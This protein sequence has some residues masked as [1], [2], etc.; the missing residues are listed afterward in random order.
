[1]SNA[2]YS[3]AWAA[4]QVSVGVCAWL[5]MAS[6][7]KRSSRR[8]HVKGSQRVACAVLS[9]KALAAALGALGVTAG[10]LHPTRFMGQATDM[11]GMSVNQ[12]QSTRS[13]RGVRTTTGLPST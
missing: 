10:W 4:G 1:M 2:R 13:Y 11:I 12:N 6:V 3:L 9:P 8:L 5:R 7:A